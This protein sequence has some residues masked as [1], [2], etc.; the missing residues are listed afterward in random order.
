MA[1]APRHHVAV[2]GRA[3][4]RGRGVLAQVTATT[5]LMNI[6]AETP[7]DNISWPGALAIAA[8]AFAVA[9]VLGCLYKH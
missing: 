3:G 6:L 9:Y 7:F 4:R 5:N 1:S 8:I 2:A